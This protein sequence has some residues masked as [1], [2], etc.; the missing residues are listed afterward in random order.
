MRTYSR[1]YVHSMSAG[2]EHHPLWAA[3]STLLESASGN[4][5]TAI[6]GP[7]QQ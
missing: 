4:N 6:V 2:F 1:M 7:Q 3:Y 5:A